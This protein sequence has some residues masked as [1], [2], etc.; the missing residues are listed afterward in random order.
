MGHSLACLGT[1]LLRWPIL[2][3]TPFA[4]DASQGYCIMIPCPLACACAG[5]TCHFCRQKKLCGEPDC[6]RC[7]RRDASAECIGK[8][9]CSRCMSATGRFCRACLSI[10]YGQ[11]LEDVRA[12]AE[13]LCPHCAEVRG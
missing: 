12:N 7:Q 9:C 5:I 10:R 13:W 1:L 11:A 6:P 3:A 2:P 4:D 8:T